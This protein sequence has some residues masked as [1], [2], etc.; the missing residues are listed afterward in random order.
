[1]DDYEPS[2]EMNDGKATD[3]LIEDL[4]AL[5]YQETYDAEQFDEVYT[6]IVRSHIDPECPD[7]VASHAGRDRVNTGAV[8]YLVMLQLD[9]TV[10]TKNSPNWPPSGFHFLPDATT[11]VSVHYPDGQR[12]SDYT[13]G[14]SINQASLAAIIQIARELSIDHHNQPSLDLPIRYDA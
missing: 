2:L 5:I 6:T 13:P 14:R 9:F 10:I 3:M 8:H 4:L 11:A 12:Q 1:M 7:L